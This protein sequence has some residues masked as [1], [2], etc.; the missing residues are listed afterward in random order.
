[1]QHRLDES[2]VPLGVEAK[3]LNAVL[4]ARCLGIGFHKGSS[5]SPAADSLFHLLVAACTF[6]V[7]CLSSLSLLVL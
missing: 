4:G 5:L 6:A 7:Q 2:F 1:M 3:D